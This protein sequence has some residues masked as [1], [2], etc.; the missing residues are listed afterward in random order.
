MNEAKLAEHIKKYN[1]E[2][3]T[4]VMQRRLFRRD[5]CDHMN[6]KDFGTAQLKCRDCGTIIGTEGVIPF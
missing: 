1:L 3:E 5:G 2:N 6:V 4:P